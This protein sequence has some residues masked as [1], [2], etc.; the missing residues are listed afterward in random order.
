M[1]ANPRRVAQ[2]DWTR[3]A[4]LVPASAGT[5]RLHLEDMDGNRVPGEWS[6]LE[7]QVNYPSQDP[8]ALSTTV[9]TLV[10]KQTEQ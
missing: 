2:R 4:V 5:Y 1:K 10:H 9:M 7:M 3:K 6:I 8:R